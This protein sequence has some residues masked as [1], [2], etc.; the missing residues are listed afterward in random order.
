MNLTNQ[1]RLSRLRRTAAFLLAI[2]LT[3][4]AA[5]AIEPPPPDPAQQRTWLTG[6]ILSDM[7]NLG[8]FP[9]GDSGEVSRIVNSLNDQQVALLARFYYLTRAKTVEDASLQAQKQQGNTEQQVNE[10]RALVADVL[11]AMDDQLQTC[12]AQLV[13][14]PAQYGMPL[15]SVAPVQYLAQVVYASLPGWCCSAQCLVPAWYY[16]NGCYVGPCLNAGYAGSWGVPVYGAYAN[17]YSH[18]W[19]VYNAVNRSLHVNRSI[20]LANRQTQ[21]WRTNLRG[22]QDRG[23]IAG[24]RLA[25]PRPLVSGVKPSAN[26]VSAS[27]P[28]VPRGVAHASH[29]KPAA[30]AQRVAHASPRPAASRHSQRVARHAQSGAKHASRSK[31]PAR[32]SSTG[33]ARVSRPKAHAAHAKPAAHGHPQHVSHA[34]AQHAAH[35]PSH[36]GHARR[37]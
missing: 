30:H 15:A 5:R 7:Q 10:A 16:A 14:A 12:Y 6:H 17:H 2:F 20:Q 22:W 21:W 1:A 11:T 4:G 24:P 8:M 3:C 13:P 32:H 31:A 18:F 35:A 25:H 33:H 28:I 23:R 36:S 9:P 26:R 37:K 34:H 27:H 29:P 19:S